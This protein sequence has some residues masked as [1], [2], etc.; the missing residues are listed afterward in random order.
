MDG[1]GS[2]L[3]CSLEGAL[4]LVAK[5]MPAAVILDCRADGIPAPRL[6]TRLKQDK[7]TRPAPVV[8]LVAPQADDKHIALLQAGADVTFVRP[9]V[10]ARLLAYLR[11]RVCSADRS[12]EYA[13]A[14]DDIEM[15]PDSYRVRRRGQEIQ[16]SSIEFHI[17][18]HLVDHRGQ[19]FSREALIG[20]AWPT[21]IHVSLRTV[22]VHVSRMRK[23]LRR[24]GCHA[25]SRTIRSEGYS[26][27][28]EVGSC[29]ALEPNGMPRPPN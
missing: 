5:K 25:L 28:D 14:F 8:A 22:D 17:L 18:R 21:T 20:V 9:L 13:L 16:L 29:N 24:I 7:I 23:A 4:Q 1:F 2:E 11:K 19:A 26:F 27:G 12:G 15:R 3:A 10:P 6:C